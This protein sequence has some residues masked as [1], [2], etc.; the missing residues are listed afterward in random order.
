MVVPTGKWIRGRKINTGKRVIKEHVLA[1][2]E[3]QEW[4]PD[5]VAHIDIPATCESE[6]RLSRKVQDQPGQHSETP[7]S[8]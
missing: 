6:M 7:I 3:H 4:I 2:L 5:M 1:I 8:K